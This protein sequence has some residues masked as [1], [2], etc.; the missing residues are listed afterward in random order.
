MT[1]LSLLPERLVQRGAGEVATA[2]ALAGAEF[3]CLYFSASWCPPCRAFTPELSEWVTSHAA[4][5]KAIFV[6]A[7]NDKSAKEAAEYWGEHQS[8]P[9]MIR[10]ED[11]KAVSRLG[12]LFKVEGIP[13]LVV[14][15]AATGR[16]V[17]AN[18]RAALSTEPANFPWRTPSVAELLLRAP[19]VAP[20]GGGAPLPTQAFLDGLDRLALYFSAHVS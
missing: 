13:S 5:H 15:D 11:G 1:L 20:P 14:L 12:S 7:S 8:L 18:A 6:F 9:F 19:A 17:N 3:V 10:F 4:A 2:T 16:V